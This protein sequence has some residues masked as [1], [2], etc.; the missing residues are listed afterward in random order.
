MLFVEGLLDFEGQVKESFD[1]DFRPFVLALTSSNPLIQLV[2]N[3]IF[4]SD[5]TPT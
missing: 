2:M 5:V 1:S 4:N 3:V